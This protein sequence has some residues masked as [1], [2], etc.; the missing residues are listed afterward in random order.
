MKVLHV[1]EAIE[2]GTARHLSYLVRYVD[3]EH[4]VVVPPE[5]V[6]GFT[7]T[8]LLD[9]MRDIGVTVHIVPMRRSPA[10]RHNM[11]AIAHVSALIHRHKPDVVHGH[12][13]IGG[14][15]ARVAA[16]SS[17]AARIYTAHGVFPARYAI[18]I[19]RT[20]GHVTDRFIALSQ[21][22]AE[23][24]RAFGL[25]PD[26]R[27]VV[28]PNAIELD[29][30][31]PATHDVREK[32]GVGPNTPIVGTVARLVP[33][34]APEVF[35]RAC[36]GVAQRAP[37]AR[38]VLVGNGPQADLVESEISRLGLEDRF[39]QLQHC[40]EGARLI[41]QFDVFALPSRYEAGAYAPMEAMRA[42]APLVLTDVVGNRDAIEDGISG[43]TVPADAPD[44]LADQIVR[45]LDDGALRQRVAAAATR[46]LRE[47][48]DIRGVAARLQHLYLEA[49]RGRRR[50]RARTAARR[51]YTAVVA[52]D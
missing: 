22:E 18:A 19:E 16:M 13:S 5:R 50:V 37:D 1:L 42:G 7:D 12:S 3:A 17:R 41:T 34:K 32:L 30:P 11:T 27:L 20:L 10:S 33:Q 4:V 28:V 26:D 29:P 23:Q 40:N 49:A 14:A 46:R 21:S 47:H 31:P 36:A 39:L 35:V 51:D 15:I 8:G 44:A 6:G 48:F 2:G 45:L 25:V 9:M 52:A 43:F 24:V 38:F